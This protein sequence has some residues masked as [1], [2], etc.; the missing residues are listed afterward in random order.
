MSG[1][2]KQ[3][4]WQRVVDIMPALRSASNKRKV[5]PLSSGLT[6]LSYRIEGKHGFVRLNARCFRKAL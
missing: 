5:G 3:L 4:R 6:K 2:A 1:K